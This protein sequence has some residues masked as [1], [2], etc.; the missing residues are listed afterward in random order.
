[1]G[2]FLPWISNLFQYII[3]FCQYYVDWAF[4]ILDHYLPGWKLV[5]LSPF[6]ICFIILPT[7]VLIYTYISALLLYLYRRR[8]KIYEGYHNHSLMEGHK[9]MMAALWSG[10]G[11]IWHGYEVK[12]LENIPDKGAALIVYYHGAIPI[13]IYYLN[14]NLYIEKSRTLFSVMD[15]IMLKIPGLEKFFK[16]WGCF[17]GPRDR[18]VQVLRNG[19][20]VSV[21]PGGVREAFFSENY[22]VVW[23][24]R[25][26][27]A[28]AALEAKVP[29]IPVFTENIRE[30]FEYMQTGRAFFKKF[31]EKT[32]WPLRPLYGGFPVKLTTYVGKPI[33]YEADITPEELVTRTRKAIESL[34]KRH[35]RRPGSI[36]LS[37]LQRFSSTKETHLVRRPRCCSDISDI[38]S[39]GD[40]AENKTCSTSNGRSSGIDASRIPFLTCRCKECNGK[41]SHESCISVKEE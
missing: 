12:G 24:K 27:F 15:N 28:K 23:G 3:A 14:A 5:V 26:G 16:F 17:P 37:C 32:R 1:M 7:L 34:I 4:S 21:A 40:A 8:H 29:I 6:V 2:F 18:V 30:A 35:Q 19:D 13:D 39:D 20:L 41:R 38:S 33:R 22:S 11:W 10:H 25:Q 9:K 36:F 31:Y